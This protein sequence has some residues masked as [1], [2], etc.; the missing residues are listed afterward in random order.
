MNRGKA[1]GVGV[2]LGGLLLLG[3][4]Q[5]IP[6]IPPIPP[7]EAPALQASVGSIRDGIRLTWSAVDRAT[8]YRI[9]RAEAPEAGYEVIGEEPGLS[10][11]DQVGVENQGKWYWYQVQACNESGCGPKSA[12]VKGY[13]GRPPAPENLQATTDPD[14]IVLTW[15][16]V[17]GATSYQVFRD[18]QSG[19]SGRCFLAE[20][21]ESKYEDTP[22]DPG[23]RYQYSVRACNSFGCSADSGPVYGCRGSCPPLSES[24]GA[25]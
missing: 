18:R 13:A 19:C 25:E 9:L 11:T 24:D 20:A 23:L 15:D 14:K 6:E 22:A 8:S 12:A 4:C 3:G 7:T 2:L 1:L 16:A 21:T 10:F 17:P 5:L